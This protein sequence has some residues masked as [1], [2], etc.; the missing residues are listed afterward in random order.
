MFFTSVRVASA[1]SPARRTDT[2]AST[3]KLPFSMSQSEMP[4]Y[5]SSCFKFWR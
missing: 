2:F 5:S 3:R 4:M 1:V